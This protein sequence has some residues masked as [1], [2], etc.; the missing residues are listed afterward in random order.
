MSL[1]WTLVGI[2]TESEEL[3]LTERSIR[4]KSKRPQTM[5][6]IKTVSRTFTVVR[7]GRRR[8]SVSGIKAIYSLPPPLEGSVW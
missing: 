4:K 3:R 5:M 8:V 1:I 2:R 7:C 6:Q